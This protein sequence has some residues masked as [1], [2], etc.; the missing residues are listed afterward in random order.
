MAEVV[1]FADRQSVEQSVAPDAD[2]IERIEELLADAKAGKITWLAYTTIKVDDVVRHGYVGPN[3][4]RH[5]KVAA[6]LYLQ[7]FV[8]SDLVMGEP[9]A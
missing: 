1:S 8:E 9:D 7:R 6:V 2:L 5:T 3:T 4:C